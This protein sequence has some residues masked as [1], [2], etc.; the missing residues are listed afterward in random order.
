MEKC[1]NNVGNVTRPGT[2]EGGHLADHIQQQL[3]APFSS[4]EAN[5]ITLP[6]AGGIIYDPEKNDKN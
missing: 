5:C 4:L 2:P 1:A 3:P 6:V